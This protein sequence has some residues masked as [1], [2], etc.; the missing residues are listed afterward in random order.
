MIINLSINGAENVIRTH[1]PRITN[2]LLYQLS[3]LGTKSILPENFAKIKFS[4]KIKS[5]GVLFLFEPNVNDWLQGYAPNLF[6]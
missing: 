1:D 2:A 3:Y 6:W 5:I 4:F